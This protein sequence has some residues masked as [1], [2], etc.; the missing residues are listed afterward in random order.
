MDIR[1][2]LLGLLE[3]MNP[4]QAPF[5]LAHLVKP[6]EPDKKF[7]IFPSREAEIIRVWK[8]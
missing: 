4:I 8:S 1:L 6:Y 5:L 3:E 2:C 7:Y